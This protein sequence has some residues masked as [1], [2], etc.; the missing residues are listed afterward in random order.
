MNAARVE[1]VAA[2][3]SLHLLA[4]SQHRD[5]DRAAHFCLLTL[6]FFAF[7]LCEAVLGA[8]LVMTPGRIS[9]DRRVVFL[10]K[11]QKFTFKIRKK[12]KLRQ[13]CVQL[14]AGRVFGVRSMSGEICMSD[15]P[16]HY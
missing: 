7:A 11:I 10:Q 14:F 15:H 9:F 2:C 12:K 8:I 6:D 13:N 3:E 5:A 16:K 4:R 1:D